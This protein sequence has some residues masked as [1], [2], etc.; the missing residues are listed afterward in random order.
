MQASFGSRCSVVWLCPRY[1]LNFSAFFTICRTSF[2]WSTSRKAT[3]RMLAR[4][5]V[6]G[7]QG[8][9][10]KACKATHRCLARLHTLHS[11]GYTSLSLYRAP[12]RRGK[13]KSKKT[14]FMPHWWIFKSNLRDIK[15][16]V[17]SPVWHKKSKKKSC[18]FLPK[19]HKNAVCS[20]TDVKKHIFTLVR[21]GKSA[22][23]CNILKTI[24][25]P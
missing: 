6:E 17:W 10:P 21:D 15:K 7:W 1:S 18:F 23:L 3:C 2:G 25:L 4:L 9:M 12:P 13:T 22:Y 11:Q 5:R 20:D 24:F 19:S 14:G 8:Y 16:L